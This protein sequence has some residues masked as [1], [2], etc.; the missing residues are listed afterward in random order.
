ME[1]NTKDVGKIVQLEARKEWGS[2]I[3]YKTDLRFA[4][5]IFATEDGSPKKF[6][7][8]E[9]PLKL[10]AN[11]DEPGLVKKGRAKNKKIKPKVVVHLPL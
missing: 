2:G 4:Y 8:G 9:N 5:I 6:F 7:L 3:I 1:I 11:Q 10:A